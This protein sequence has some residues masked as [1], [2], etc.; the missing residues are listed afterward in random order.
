V[1]RLLLKM[2]VRLG[3]MAEWTA[4][5]ANNSAAKPSRGCGTNA[6]R[7]RRGDRSTYAL[8]QRWIDFS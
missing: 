5:G 7:S 4:E 1:D 8:S 3:P 2:P 6:L